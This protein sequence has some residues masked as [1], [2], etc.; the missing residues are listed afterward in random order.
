MNYHFSD[1]ILQTRARVF[2]TVTDLSD[3]LDTSSFVQ[4]RAEMLNPDSKSMEFASSS[5]EDLVKANCA[6]SWLQEQVNGDSKVF[7]TFSTSFNE[8]N[9]YVGIFGDLAW[10]LLEEIERS[11]TSGQSLLDERR[12]ASV[13]A[14]DFPQLALVPASTK[15][16]D[17]VCFLL[18]LDYEDPF[19]LRRSSKVPEGEPT[20]RNLHV[21]LIGNC[22]VD[23]YFYCNTGSDMYRHIDKEDHGSNDGALD[24]LSI[25]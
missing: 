3:T 19:I 4:Y 21:Y 25:H 23:D 5:R 24:L 2:A 18:S 11:A 20:S 13:E 14:E 7:T 17:L 15:V 12:L 10:Y 8:S 6:K 9:P 22:L 16:G 1:S